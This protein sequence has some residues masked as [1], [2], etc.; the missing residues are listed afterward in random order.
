MVQIYN[1]K[2]II[3]QV[4]VGNIGSPSI[5]IKTVVLPHITPYHNKTKIIGWGFP[6]SLLNPKEISIPL[7]ALPYL[8][9]VIDEFLAGIEQIKNEKFEEEK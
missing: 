3:A 4:R 2:E 8:R 9:A 6:G 1:Q 7:Y 5:E